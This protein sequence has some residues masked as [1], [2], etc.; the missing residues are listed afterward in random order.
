MRN[1]AD[2]RVKGFNL[3]EITILNCIKIINIDTQKHKLL[4]TQLSTQYKIL[5]RG[6]DAERRN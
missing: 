1:T 2:V 5:F 3:C 6:H 4:I